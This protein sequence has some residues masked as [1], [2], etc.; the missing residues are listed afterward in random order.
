MFRRAQNAS[1]VQRVPR[2]WPM[3]AEGKNPPSPRPSPPGEGETF[4]VAGGIECGQPAALG[5]LRVNQANPST[6]RPS[7]VSIPRLRFLPIWLRLGFGR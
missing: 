5:K 7:T 6:T 4:A 2:V 3:G 1:G